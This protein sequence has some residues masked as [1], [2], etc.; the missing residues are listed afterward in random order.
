MPKTI[1]VTGAAGFIGFH[2]SK[3]LLERGDKVIGIDNINDYYNVQLKED[4]LK[5][6]KEN[7]NFKF[8]KLDFSEGLNEVIEQI[9]AI[10]H[11]GAQAGVRYSITNPLIYEKYNTLG[12]LKVFEFAREKNIKSV[13]F[14]SSSSVYG[15]CTNPPFKE[16]YNIS[17]PIS[18]YA[19]TKISNELFA[20]TYHKLF[21]IN[22]T[23]LRFFTVYGPYG[24]PDMAL[25]NF[26]KKIL[27]NEVIDVYN[28]GEMKR[29]FTYVDDIVDG[30][31][32]SIDKNH[33][34]EIFNLARGESVNLMDFIKALEKALDKKAKINFMPL[35]SGDVLLTSGDISKA[36]SLLGYEPKVSIEQGVKEFVDW[37]KNYSKS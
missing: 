25:F 6:L 13:I 3:A 30:I 22:M 26:T 24:R 27:N 10:C 5:I 8:Y 31:L 37:Y 33:S 14:A 7:P 11:L 12:T 1:L 16:D 17:T 19:A 29:D 18:L 34:F 35:Q 15:N 28:N 9:D 36:K 2:T 20:Y 32:L 23:G 4:R 21:G